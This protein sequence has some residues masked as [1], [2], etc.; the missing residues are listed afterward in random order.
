[1]GNI[2]DGAVP[3]SLRTEENAPSDLLGAVAIEDSTTFPAFSAGAIREAQ[4]LGAFELDR[5]HEGHDP[6]CGLFTGVE[7]A[8]GSSDTLGVFHGVQ[9]ALNQDVAAHRE[10]CSRSRNELRQYE[11]DL[12][13]VTEERNALKLFLGQR[14][15]EIKDIQAELTKAHQDQTDL[16]EKVNVIKAESLKWK[17]NMDRFATEKEAVRARLSSAESQFQSLKEK[18]LV[19]ARKTKE[20]EARLA[21]ELAKAE[22]PKADVDAFVDVYQADTEATQSHA[23]EVADTV[24]TRAY[25]IAEFSKCQSWREIPEEIHARG[26]DLSEAI[27]DVRALASDDDG[28]DGDDDDDDD[29]GS[30]SRSQSGEEPDGEKTT[31]VDN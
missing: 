22:K 11:V 8:A 1:M 9:Q 13:W 2:F 23:R 30:K 24:R 4:A 5:P 31:P 28:D 25:W 20:L 7:D 3:E 6:F 15:E 21:S 14:G 18:N 10:V 16:S 26:F 29:D 12:Q 17:G 19:Q 27:T